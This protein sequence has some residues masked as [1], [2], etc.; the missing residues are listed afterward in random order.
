MRALFIASA[1]SLAAFAAPA[2]AEGT[3]TSLTLQNPEAA[4]ERIIIDGA[5]WRCAQGVCIASGGAS[6]PATRACRRV[7]AKLGPVSAF[8]WRGQD[9]TSEQLAACNAD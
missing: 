3:T 9:L 7:V 8:S 5:T 4:P 6:Q 1:L 2:M